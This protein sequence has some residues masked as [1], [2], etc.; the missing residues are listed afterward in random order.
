MWEVKLKLTDADNSMVVTRGK[1]VGAQW[2]VK[3][4]KYVVM[5]DGL[6]LGGGHTMQYTDHVAQKC[7][8]E[9]YVI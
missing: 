4:D 9:T 6:T 2:G 7:T 1:G 8:L 3:G 5:E